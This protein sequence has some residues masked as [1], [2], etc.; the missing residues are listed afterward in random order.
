MKRLLLVVSMLLL[1]VSAA[2]AVIDRNPQY[3]LLWNGFNSVSMVDSFAVATTKDGIVVLTPDSAGILQPV[4]HLFLNT[5]PFEQKRTGSVITVRGR[6]NVLYFVDISNL[7]LLNLLGTADLGM[8]F[9]D[10]ALFG[11]DIYV[12][13]GYKGLLRYTMVNYGSLTFADSSMIGIHCTKLDIYGS[14]LYVLD[15]YNGILR[16][17]LT[18]IGFGFYQNM[19]PVPYRATSFTK[20][21]TTI[22][23]AVYK[24]MLVLATFNGSQPHITDTVNL[25]YPPE[26]LLG[27][28]SHLV[29]LNHEYDIAEIINDG[30]RKSVISRRILTNSCV[31]GR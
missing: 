18:G 12:S 13:A 22:A 8:P 29:A 27:V 31:S 16:Y 25:F 2:D 11:Q 7:P 15:D 20:I 30:D 5:E 14:E 1:T 28:D 10:Y 19:L 3:S 26:R 24:P 17:Q 4:N 9:Y 21:D 6:E 23:V